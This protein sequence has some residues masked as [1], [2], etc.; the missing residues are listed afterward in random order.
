M[1][2]WVEKAGKLQRDTRIDEG[3]VV[4]EY[5]EGQT[6]QAVVHARQDIVL[7]VGLLDALNSQIRWV[8]WLLV[9]IAGLVIYLV[10]R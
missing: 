7:L 6:R 9:L 5:S 2:W 1:S 10:F 3:A 8:K 4:Q